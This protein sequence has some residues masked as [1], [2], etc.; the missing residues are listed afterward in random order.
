MVYLGSDNRVNSS[1]DTY[2][3]YCLQIKGYS[4][5]EKHQ[6][7]GNQ[8]LYTGFKPKFILEKEYSASNCYNWHFFLQN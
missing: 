4:K 2:V 5:I 7:T 3:A 6:G 8:L 1:G